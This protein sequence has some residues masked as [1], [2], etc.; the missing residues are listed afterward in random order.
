MSVTTDH[1]S[2]DSSVEIFILLN[3]ISKEK[4]E[5]MIT[6]PGFL[7]VACLLTT[8]SPMAIRVIQILRRKD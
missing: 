4:E 2:V 7:A 1:H 8:Y 5:E 3:R 6:D